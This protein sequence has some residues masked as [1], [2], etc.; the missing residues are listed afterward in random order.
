MDRPTR[1]GMMLAGLLALLSGSLVA[2]APGPTTEE[3]QAD[4]IGDKADETASDPVAI[5]ERYFQHLETG[6]FDRAY[7]MW[8][9]DTSTHEG[10][11]ERFGTSMLVYQS[12]DGEATGAARMEGAAGTRYAEVP[13][14]VSGTR[15]G[16][17]FSHEGTMTL[18]RCNDV[19]GC[20]AQALQWQIESI[21][22]EQR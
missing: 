12:F 21:I 11:S 13:I 18:K 6:A 8:A 22:L 7:A 17:P 19:P 5:S 16:E 15:R 4:A 1:K 2:C 10:G 3:R 14:R 20:S 9:S